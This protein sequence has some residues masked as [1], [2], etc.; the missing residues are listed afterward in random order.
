MLT[1][2]AAQLSALARA[3]DR[4]THQRAFAHLRNSIPEVCGQMSDEE[5]GAVIAWGHRRARRHGF[6]GEH[7]FFR[8]LNLMFVFGF[9][10][11]QNPE[12]PW[13]AETLGRSGLAASVKM[14]LLMDLAL[15]KSEQ[16]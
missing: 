12:H 13:A 14:D 1:I 3:G 7:D 9:E 15:L 11:D 16:A 2:R 8:Y 4:A 6:V 5:L 10:F